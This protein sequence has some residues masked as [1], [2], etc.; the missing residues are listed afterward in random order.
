M[1][2]M[3]L[4][5]K[6]KLLNLATK[7]YT[8]C[9]RILRKIKRKFIKSHNQNNLNIEVIKNYVDKFYW[10]GELLYFEGLLD[11]ELVN[12]ELNIV[13]KLRKRQTYYK[14]P[15]YKNN[16]RWRLILD[17]SDKELTFRSGLWDFYIEDATSNKKYRI[18]VNNENLFA[19]KSTFLYKT[20]KE[21][22]YMEFYITLKDGLSFISKMKTLRVEIDEVI[23]DNWL[24]TFKGTI[25]SDFSTATLSTAKIAFRQRNTGIW[26][27]YPV[28]FE[29][30]SEYDKTTYTFT[31]DYQ[32]FIP[33]DKMSATRWD[34]YLSVSVNDEIHRFRLRTDTKDIAITSKIQFED[35]EIYRLNVYSTKYKNLSFVFSKLNILRNVTEYEIKRSSLYLKGYSY[36]ETLDLERDF[37]QKRKIVIRE[38]MTENEV[39]F[40]LTEINY[41]FDLHHEEERFLKNHSGFQIQIPLDQLISLINDTKNILDI[42]INITYKGKEFERK[43]GCVKYKYFK[44]HALATGLVNKNG[45]YYRYF[46]TLTPRGNLKLETTVY[47]E[48]SYRYIRFGQYIDWFKNLNKDVWLIGERPDTA[49]DTGYHFFKYMREAHPEKEVYYVID[50]ES[51]DIDNIKQLGNVLYLGSDEHLRK[52]AIAKAFIGSHDLEYFI[53]TKPVELFSYKRSKR[54]FLQ[55]GVLGRK[56]VEY[57]KKYYKYPFHIFCVSSTPEQQMVV[58]KM[59]YSSKEVKVTGLSRFDNLLNQQRETKSILLIPTWREWINSEEAFI[60]SEYFKRYK[61]LL[62]SQ[63]LHTLLQKYDVDLKFYPH[64]RMQHF[65]EHFGDLEQGNVTVIE[66][67]EKPVQ[68]LM[69]E[70]NLMITDF[71]SVSFDFNY[72]SKPIIFYH[73]DQDQFFANGILRP[74]EETFLG[75]ICK[76]EEEVIDAIEYYLQKDFEEKQSITEKK[77]LIFDYIDQNNCQRIYNEIVHL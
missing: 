51:K 19:E 26:T 23:K 42:Y 68:N 15:L 17:L 71:S 49:Q 63:R 37:V 55:H 59:G 67:G 25:H 75:D 8:K 48:A 43:L 61:S 47:S 31:L 58:D 20:E 76:T 34:I 50:P 33:E 35:Q 13:V 18:R 56:T 7:F 62:T 66:L 9:I 53:P 65:I 40:H 21:S 1:R 5:K 6:S 24:V 38:R 54:V 73:F 64:Y 10:K 39:D 70:S 57:D 74:I 16:N 45:N 41:N 12:K 28:H 30:A 2:L 3:R 29:Q 69:L 36:L 44:D 72:M 52:A 4:L 46:L 22:R 77:Y 60:E 27:T 14:F 32:E 11:S